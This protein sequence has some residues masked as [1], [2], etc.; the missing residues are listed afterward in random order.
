[1]ALRDRGDGDTPPY[2]APE[3]L[4]GG[5]PSFAS[6][7][8]SATAV[9][10]EMLTNLLPYH[11]LGGQAGAS[12]GGRIP[13]CSLDAPSRLAPDAATMPR[14]LWNQIDEIADR[15]LQFDP[16]KRFG[17]GADWRNRLDQLNCDMRAAHEL[18]GPNKIAVKIIEAAARLFRR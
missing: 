8:F 12:S 3:V 14:R 1:M 6:D 13:A 10:Y 17:N 16:H 9:Y 5:R 11:P 7:Q 4:D 18:R 2:T 15:G